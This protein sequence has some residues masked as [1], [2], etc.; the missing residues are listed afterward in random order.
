MLESGAWTGRSAQANAMARRLADAMPFPLAHPV[1]TNAVFV[2]MD[3]AALARL[4]AEG[5]AAHRSI[6]GSVRFMCSWAT[7]AEQVDELGEALA[8]VA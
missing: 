7:S 2:A 8:R 6:D 3:E 4:H 1:E 5:W